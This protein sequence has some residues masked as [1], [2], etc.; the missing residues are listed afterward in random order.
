MSRPECEFYRL[1]PQFVV[2]D[3]VKSA[4]YY[5]DKFGFDII[6]YFLDPP[7]F[8]IVRRDG[9]E[10]H[11]GKSDKGEV[12]LNDSVRKGLGTDTYIFI[13]DV[14]SLHEELK[15]R[16]ANILEGPVERPYNRTEITVVDE[17]GYQIVFG[18]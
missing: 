7:V 13:S 17:N 1:A 11:L 2:P 5:R 10:I 15:S 9:A 12:N 14:S 16:G 18:Q 4:E 8:A 3:V 6:G